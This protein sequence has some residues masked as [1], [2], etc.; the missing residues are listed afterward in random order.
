MDNIIDKFRCYDRLSH[1][2]EFG[3]RQ[4]VFKKINGAGT[5]ANLEVL[6]LCIRTTL[7]KM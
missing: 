7:I 6:K 1:L 5:R 3:V 2:G 4:T